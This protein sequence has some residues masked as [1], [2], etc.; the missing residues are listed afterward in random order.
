MTPRAPARSTRGRLLLAIPAGAAAFVLSAH[1]FAPVPA[2]AVVEAAP[3]RA[4]AVASQVPAPAVADAPST[5]PQARLDAQ[6]RYNPFGPLNLQAPGIAALGKPQAP[7]PAPTPAKVVEPAPVPPPPPVAPPLPFTA[8]GSIEGPDVTAGQALA[9][10]QH[11][12]N[13]LVV[14]KGESIGQLYRV[15]SV[16]ADRVEF[17]YLPLNQRQFL[18]LT[19]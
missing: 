4:S 19:R 18:A 12:D 8:I 15:E 17:T 7:K 16:S 6:M 14:R 5:A 13:L 2:D 11:Q 9:F 1:F 3:R 10:L